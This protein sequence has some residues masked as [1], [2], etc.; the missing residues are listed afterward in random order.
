[1]AKEVDHTRAIAFA[2]RVGSN[3]SNVDIANLSRAYIAMRAV[4][5]EMMQREQRINDRL[6][7]LA[8]SAS[9]ARK[10]A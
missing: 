3:S 4:V 8:A 6:E 10:S 9:K 2:A 7:V 5:E 1:M